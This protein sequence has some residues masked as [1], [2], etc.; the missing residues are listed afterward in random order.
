MNKQKHT[1]C[2]VFQT[3]P[4]RAHL[5]T[6]PIIGVFE[7]LL[8]DENQ[9]NPSPSAM[10][11]EKKKFRSLAEIEEEVLAE[12]QEWMRQRLQ[13]RLQEQANEI[14]APFPPRQPSAGSSAEKKADA[15]HPGGRAGR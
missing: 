9:P 1:D 7:F 11:N 8:R 15:A 5:D 13:E 14:G 3:Q 6:A 2:I 4:K 10:N 12:G